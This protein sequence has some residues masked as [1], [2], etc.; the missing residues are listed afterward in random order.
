MR[1]RRGAGN[2]A[3]RPKRRVVSPVAPALGDK[4]E[5]DEVEEEDEDDSD[6]EEDEEDEVVNEVRRPCDPGLPSV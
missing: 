4:E 1:R 5:E 2:M 6:E 3:S